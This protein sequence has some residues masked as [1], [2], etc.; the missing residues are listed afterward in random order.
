[1]EEFLQ[2]MLRLGDFAWELRIHRLGQLLRAPH[3]VADRVH[4]WLAPAEDD[5]PPPAPH[6]SRNFVAF[7]CLVKGTLG[8]ATE[9]DPHPYRDLPGG[10]SKHLWGALFP[11]WVIA[12]NSMTAGEAH[13]VGAEWANEWSQWCAITRAPGTPATQYAALALEGWGP[14]TQPRPTVI[15]RTGPERLWAAETTEWLRAAPEPHTGWRGD[16]SSL[17]WAPPP[18]ASCST[19]PTYSRLRRYARGGATQPL[20]SHSPQR[21]GAPGLPWGISKKGGLRTMTPC[22]GWVTFRDPCSSCSPLTSP[23]RCAGSWTATTR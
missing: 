13:I 4:R 22:P 9:K 10:F 11:L 1:M 2:H 5:C 15:C 18:P 6:P 19:P 7:L 21:R 20:S 14:H 12:R 23:L 16:V 8:C 3:S 17:L